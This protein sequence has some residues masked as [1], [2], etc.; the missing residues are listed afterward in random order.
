MSTTASRPPDGGT[1]GGGPTVRVLLV[2]DQPALREAVTAVVARTAGFEVV[3]ESGDGESALQLAEELDPDLVLLDVRMSPM[4]GFET[5]HR[6]HSQS[7]GRVIVLLTGS[8]VRRLEPL[9]SVSP[10]AA[11]VPKQKLNS[12]LLRELWAQHRRR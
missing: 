4:D 1:P 7:A 9:A 10:V 11:L 5:A 2:D 12:A 6:L 8:D 3:G